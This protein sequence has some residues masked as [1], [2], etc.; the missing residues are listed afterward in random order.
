MENEKE[1]G[2][3]EKEQCYTKE[4]EVPWSDKCLPPCEWTPVKPEGVDE[5]PRSDSTHH[6]VPWSDKSLPP[7]QWSPIKPANN[8][9]TTTPRKSGQQH[10]NRKKL[11]YEEILVHLEDKIKVPIIVV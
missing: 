7:A 8:D 5:N 11:G 1:E 6:Q 3:T 4:Q 9:T 10:D 2:K